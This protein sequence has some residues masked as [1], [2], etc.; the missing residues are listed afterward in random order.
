MIELVNIVFLIIYGIFVPVTLGMLGTR[1]LRQYEDSLA[2]A[3]ITGLVFMMALF[4][5][6]AVPMI[7]MKQPFHLLAIIWKIIIWCLV[8]ISL[9]LNVK[10]FF[11][12]VEEKLL[13]VKNFTLT[14]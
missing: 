2:M 14:V 13:E 1:R 11:S 7:L 6:L 12:L 3:A 8:A 5:L 4:E 9:V 10:R